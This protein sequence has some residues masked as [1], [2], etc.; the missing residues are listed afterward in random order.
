[1][2]PDPMPDQSVMALW[3]LFEFT[4]LFVTEALLSRLAYSFT[5]R[6]LAT[7]S[8]PLSPLI[9]SPAICICN[10]HM[11]PLLTLSRTVL[12]N[13]VYHLM[14]SLL[15]RGTELLH[16]LPRSDLCQLSMLMEIF[17][18]FLECLHLLLLPSDSLEI[19]IWFLLD[20]LL[21]AAS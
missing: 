4:S 15:R 11:Y 18:F 3:K 8:W 6:T 5:T 7:F 10:C 19:R 13:W 17:Q 2:N 14:S 9:A 21:L 20:F 16:G 12:L 1:M